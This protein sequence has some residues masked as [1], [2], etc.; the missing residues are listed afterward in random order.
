MVRVHQTQTSTSWSA[1]SALHYHV[2]CVRMSIQSVL[3]WNN[4]NLG[5]N[6]PSWTD[7][8]Y[9][10]KKWSLV[11]GWHIF[12]ECRAMFCEAVAPVTLWQFSQSLLILLLPKHR[13]FNFSLLIHDVHILVP[14]LL[15]CHFTFHWL[16]NSASVGNYNFRQFSSDSS[17][18]N[19]I[20]HR[21]IGCSNVN[22]PAS[23]PRSRRW[24]PYPLPLIVIVDTSEKMEHDTMFTH[25]GIAMVQLSPQIPSLD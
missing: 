12:R 5:W 11:T 25:K 13:N 15:T 21:N 22:L 19:S 8:R 4:V 14:C 24:T 3:M 18:W 9:R 1:F 16:Q 10:L 20:S 2:L 23:Y 6:L 17:K 7:V